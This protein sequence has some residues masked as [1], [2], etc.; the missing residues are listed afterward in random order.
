MEGAQGTSVTFTPAKANHVASLVSTATPTSRFALPEYSLLEHDYSAERVA[1]YF[2]DRSL[3]KYAL[4]AFPSLNIEPIYLLK[5]LE[6]IDPKKQ[7]QVIEQSQEIL[8]R[9]PESSLEA[10][11]PN[12]F[13]STDYRWNCHSHA[14]SLAGFDF[15]AGKYWVSGDRSSK[16]YGTNPYELILKN[17]FTEVARALPHNFGEIEPTLL[18]D[19]DIIIVKTVYKEYLHSGSIVFNHDRKHS[20]APGGLWIRTKLGHGPVF[21]IPFRRF[22]V[23]SEMFVPWS[24]HDQSVIDEVL[25]FRR[26]HN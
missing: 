8:R 7:A 24:G 2:F 13:N 9:F 4:L 17:F 25:I 26:R 21:N 12:P 18:R 19:G 11:N 23:L 10:K 20:L 3:F 15:L 22:A 1:E 14:L 16:T 6:I 5:L